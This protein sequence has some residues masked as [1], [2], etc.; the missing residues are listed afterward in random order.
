M[1]NIDTHK[2]TNKQTNTQ[3]ENIITSL[4]R[5]LK[6]SWKITFLKFL[7]N[8]PG[9]NG[10]NVYLEMMW[11]SS[12]VI[13]RHSAGYIVGTKNSDDPSKNKN[14]QYFYDQ[15]QEHFLI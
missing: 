9:A 3:G 10:L 4:S 1:T 5:V 12:K 13:S 15:A 2:Q 8:L 7:W 14:S 6:I 11:H